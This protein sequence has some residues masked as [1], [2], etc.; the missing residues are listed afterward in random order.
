MR[1]VDR[2]IGIETVRRSVYDINSAFFNRHDNWIKFDRT[3][4]GGTSLRVY[5]VPQLPE[6][7][8]H[9]AA[10]SL[11]RRL[12]FALVLAAFRLLVSVCPAFEAP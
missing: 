8:L 2:H 1:Q 9:A 3:R 7:A 11:S 12:A 6:L 10:M 4:Q 5:A